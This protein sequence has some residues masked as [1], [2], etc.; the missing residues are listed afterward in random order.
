MF[1]CNTALAS[2]FPANHSVVG[3]DGG[4]L[5]TKDESLFNKIDAI[6]KHGQKGRYNYIEVGV[7]SRLILLASILLKKLKIFED[8]ISIKNDIA[9]QYNEIPSSS[10][11]IK[12]PYIPNDE[13]RSVWAQYTILL[14]I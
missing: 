8:E 10:N 13:N 5:H 2:F 1:N 3:G 9:K 4:A 14:D 11:A 7:N 12:T 6:S